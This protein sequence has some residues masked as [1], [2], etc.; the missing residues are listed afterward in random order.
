MINHSQ[1]AARNVA[2]YLPKTRIIF[3]KILMTEGRNIHLR[4][5]SISYKLLKLT[6]LQNYVSNINSITD[7]SK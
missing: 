5:S 3:H 6:L 1:C 7:K 2:F 4:D